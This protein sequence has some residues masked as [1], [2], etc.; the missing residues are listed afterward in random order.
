MHVYGRE[1]QLR[2]AGPAV[3]QTT[4]GCF[5]DAKDS[6]LCTAQQN[7]LSIFSHKLEINSEKHIDTKAELL[8]LELEDCSRMV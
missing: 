7:A 5:C 1:K 8:R 6:G 3:H 2:L 4:E